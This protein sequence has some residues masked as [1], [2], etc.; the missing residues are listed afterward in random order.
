MSTDFHH[1]G[2]TAGKTYYY[3]V[4]ATDNAG[5]T[6]TGATASMKAASELNPPTNGSI[7]I[8][9]GVPYTNS[10]AVKLTLSATDDSGPVAKMCISNTNAC[11]SWV[12]YATSKAWTLTAG[13][14]VKTVNVWFRDKFDNDTP[15]PYSATI[16]L[17]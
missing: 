1:T 15:V 14:G 4:C 2:L 12:P 6:T 16:T 3:R 7:S 13:N 17:Q 10:T 5:N 11:S 9:A 8:N